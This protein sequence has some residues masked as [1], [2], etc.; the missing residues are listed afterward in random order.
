V[1]S[2]PPPVSLFRTVA[3]D[4]QLRWHTI[5]SSPEA[6]DNTGFHSMWERPM[7]AIVIKTSPC[8]KYVD[9]PE[10]VVPMTELDPKDVLTDLFDSDDLPFPNPEAAA[11][12]VIQ[13]L[14]DAGFEIK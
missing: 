4:K 2:A 7:R 12:I 3:D 9:R 6:F 8:G 13:R 1:R 11:E 14:T 5:S 10:G